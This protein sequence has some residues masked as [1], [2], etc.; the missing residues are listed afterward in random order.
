MF[1]YFESAFEDVTDMEEVGNVGDATSITFGGYDF[2]CYRC[3]FTS[4]EGWTSGKCP[5]CGSLT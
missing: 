4:I 2:S 5:K 3:G 1:D